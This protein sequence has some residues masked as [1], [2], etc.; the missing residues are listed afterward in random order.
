MSDEDWSL[1]DHPDLER[2]DECGLLGSED[3]VPEHDCDVFL[4]GGKDHV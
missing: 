3:E 4:A 2:C 1:F